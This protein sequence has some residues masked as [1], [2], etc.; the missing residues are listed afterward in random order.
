VADP[1]VERM[2]SGRPFE[3]RRNIARGV[4]N[5]ARALQIF[6]WRSAMRGGLRVLAFSLGHTIEN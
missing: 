6:S 5:A 1:C 4:G 3:V 2:R